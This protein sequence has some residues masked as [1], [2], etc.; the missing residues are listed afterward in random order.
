MHRNTAT[1]VALTTLTAMTALTA[2]ATVDLAYSSYDVDFDGWQARD[3]LNGNITYYQPDWNAAG[4]MPTGHIEFH[5]I[6]AGG[7]VFEAPTQFTGD[8]SAAIGNGG[9]SFDW[10]ADMIQD[11][12]R[13][14]V[15]FISNGVRL[16]T[17]SDP[18]PIAGIWHSFNFNFDATGGWNVDY[19][20]GG[21]VQAAT[22]ADM[23]NVLSSVTRMDITGE[24]WTG[25]VETTWLDNPRIYMSV[26]APGALALLGL[27]SLAGTGRR[28]R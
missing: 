14:S 12:K 18:D 5:D 27:A 4:G 19:G 28:R 8:F 6:T 11:G 13:A 17:G 15:I 26:P 25:I 24:T 23:Y 21:G 9:V 10:M 3:T 20:L 7:Y 22:T 2:A 1:I 16:W